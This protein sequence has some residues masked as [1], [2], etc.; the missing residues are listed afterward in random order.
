MKHFQSNVENEL[1]QDFVS[2]LGFLVDKN[3]WAFSA[4]AGTGSMVVL[5]FGK[6]VPRTPVLTNPNLTED[7]RR[8]TG[9]AFLFLQHAAWRLDSQTEIICGSTDSN[10]LEG[11]MVHGLRRLVSTKA[12]AV[13]ILSPFL[14]LL[15]EFEGGIVLT[16]FCD[17]TNLE[18]ESDNYSLHV[19]RTAFV[20]ATRSKLIVENTLQP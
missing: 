16:V 14:D 13:Y 15:I 1:P 12:K 4:G 10:E 7:Q 19:N 18:D 2:A 6:K 8:F 5:D 9:E 3:C 20:V 11:P 17:Q